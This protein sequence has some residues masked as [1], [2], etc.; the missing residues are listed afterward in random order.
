MGDDMVV[1]FLFDAFARDELLARRLVSFGGALTTWSS[2]ST[3]NLLV[4]SIGRIL[5]WLF[6]S[7]TGG[8]RVE[9]VK[10]HPKTW[11]GGIFECALGKVS[12]RDIKVSDRLTEEES[13]PVCK[14]L[15]VAAESG[16]QRPILLPPRS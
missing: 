3:E 4:P 10:A 7:N 16:A 5:Y 8:G 9:V 14:S 12:I 11:G 2:V 6:D 1:V 13:S 15:V